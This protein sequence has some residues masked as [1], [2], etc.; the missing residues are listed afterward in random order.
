LSNKIK[1]ENKF[2]YLLPDRIVGF[3]KHFLYVILSIITLFP[4]YF[5]IVS[6]FK[7][8]K[9]YAISALSLPHNPVLQNFT[10]TFKGN[11]FWLWLM[12][13]VILTVGSILI[14]LIIALFAAFA[15]S[16][17]KFWGKKAMLNIIVSLM[18]IPPIVMVIPLFR[19]MAGINLTNNYASV[20]LIYSALLLP[21]TIYL[22]TNFFATIPNSLLE[23][24]R[25][26]GCTD[27]RILFNIIVP[28]ARPAIITVIVVNSLW[29]W[30]ELLIALIFL[31][32]NKMKTLMVGIALF[33]TRYAINV[34]VTMA[35]MVMATVPM[36]V[37][38]IF[39]Q[40]Y[41]VRGISS[42][43]IKG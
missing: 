30:S 34:P 18:V 25:I 42:G 12:N 43:A 38:Y 15:F 10:E 31:Q 24:A 20:I 7:T 40:R 37:L 4:V 39:G 33:K 32:S 28:L 16:K 27:I 5:I 6:A 14:S 35:A 22:L 9:E 29:T 17:M 11:T 36:I 2:L 13:S 41:F 23:S 26:D 3:V 19:L 21:F 1:S 8:K